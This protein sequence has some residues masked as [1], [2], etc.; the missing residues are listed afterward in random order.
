MLRHEEYFRE[1]TS[2][3]LTACALVARHFYYP[4]DIHNALYNFNRP[5][6]TSLTICVFIRE[7]VNKHISKVFI[8]TFV[9]SRKSGSRQRVLAEAFLVSFVVIQFLFSFN[10]LSLSVRMLV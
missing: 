5:F 2:N 7:L 1:L 3:A 4:L 10:D 9:N 8:D 6:L